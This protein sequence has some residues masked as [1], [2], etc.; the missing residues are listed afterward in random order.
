MLQVIRQCCQHQ[1][2][3]SVGENGSLTDMLVSLLPISLLIRY[4]NIKA[5]VQM[6]M[7]K[8]VNSCTPPHFLKS[9]ENSPAAC[10]DYLPAESPHRSLMQRE[11]EKSI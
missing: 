4:T 5:G 10:I 9:V 3:S 2:N 11:Q 8:C 6:C 7:S 1:G